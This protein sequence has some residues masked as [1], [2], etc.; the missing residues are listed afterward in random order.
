MAS[1]QTAA[2][3]EDGPTASPVDDSTSDVR[4]AGILDLSNHEWA[5]DVFRL[6]VDLLND[7]TDGF[8]DDELAGLGGQKSK[9]LRG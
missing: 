9:S 8:F 7:R 1:S 6:T 3:A 4:L 2:A 5:S